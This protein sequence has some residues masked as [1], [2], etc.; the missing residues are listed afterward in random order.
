MELETRYVCARLRA[1]EERLK[2][3]S[4]VLEDQ[5]DDGNGRPS[6][7]YLSGYGRGLMEARAHVRRLREGLAN[8]AG[9]D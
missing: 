4:E 3:A 5:A 9:L 1:I 8:M 7:E 6:G 2:A